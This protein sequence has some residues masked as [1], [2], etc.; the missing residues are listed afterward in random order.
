VLKGR[1][2]AMGLDAGGLS[3]LLDGQ[4]QNIMS[5]MP[6]GLGSALGA[7]PGL[8][9][10]TQKAQDA[11]EWTSDRASDAYDT[12][13]R[14]VSGGAGAAG[15]W[16]VPIL[17]L[18]V[19]IGLIWWIASR[20]ASKPQVAVP[21]PS[22]QQTPAETN[23]TNPPVDNS[24]ASLA[25]AKLPGADTFAV[26]K[27]QISGFFTS[28]TEA[29][30]GITD[31]ASAETALPK[32]R[33]LNGKLD[34]VRTAIGAMPADTKAQATSQFTTL[35]DSLKPKIDKVMA[36]PGVSEKIKPVVD[37]MMTKFNGIMGR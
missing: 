20:S 26:A 27:D 22:R 34:D 5:A 37:D 6:A 25:A 1:K 4:K 9:G 2:Q 10:L 11:K 7:L 15:R 18:V 13:R 30:N 29:F 23:I 24:N 14:A 19:L 33:D 21:T 12:G 8:G 16:L 3:N 32:L 36:I 17:G 31:A 28:S 35:F